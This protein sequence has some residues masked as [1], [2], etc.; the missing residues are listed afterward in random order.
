MVPAPRFSCTD[1][2]RRLPPCEAAGAHVRMLAL[3][4]GLWSMYSRQVRDDSRLAFLYCVSQIDPSPEALADVLSEMAFMQWIS[5]AT[6][7][8]TV[9]QIAM[10]EVAT[11]AKRQYGIRDWK[12]VWAIVREYVPDLVKYTLVK[13]AGGVPDLRKAPIDDEAEGDGSWA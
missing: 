1:A 13:Q 6:Q 3:Q 8:Q 10:R 5:E 11:C 9:C 2:L 4:G 12:V 7:Y